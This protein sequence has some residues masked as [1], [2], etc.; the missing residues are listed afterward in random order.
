MDSLYVMRQKLQEVYAAHSIV[1]DKIIQFAVAL[2]TFFFINKNIGFMEM[3]AQPVAT[4][5]LAVI[6]T[7]F[8]FTMTIVVAAALVLLHLF[9]GSLGMMAVTALV[10]L[11]MFA[12]YFRLTPKMALVA[13]LTPIAFMLKIPYV[14]PIAYALIQGPVCVIAICCGT[15]VYFMMEYVKKAVPAL[16]GGEAAGLL[17]Q[18]S[19][20][21]KQVFQN[22]E[23]WIT[24]AAFI[25]CYLVV[26]TI[27]RQAIDHAWKIAIL[28][29][30]VVNVI[31]ITV[32]D[33]AL[34]VDTSF[35]TL[36]FGSVAAIIVGVILE[37][38][39]FSVDY[40]RSENLQY[41]DDEYYYYVKAVPK[42]SIAS[43][44]KTVK[45]INERQETE[46]IDAEEVRRRA[47]RAEKAAKAENAPAK[48]KAPEGKRPATKQNVK[49]PT[50]RPATKKGPS[51]KRQD[52]AEVDKMLLTQSLRKDLNLDE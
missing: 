1:F 10:F 3:A 29:G 52:M 17:E 22:K 25:I 51:T 21:I 34:G 8:P 37:L 38:F 6:C 14:V 7:F 19:A 50:K 36:I 4:L 48:R 35:G 46:I 32:G 47:E 26:Y 31:V 24:I 40:A 20:Y 42:L 18:I 39:F 27:R 5:A 45:R 41:E 16:Q 9:A 2:T 13:L 49:K 23:L 12:L 28:A 30:A 11:I 43:P 15:V 33:I 44:E